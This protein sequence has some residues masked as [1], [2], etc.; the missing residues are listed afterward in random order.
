[1]GYADWRCHSNDSTKTD[2]FAS[3]NNVGLLNMMGKLGLTYRIHVCCRCGYGFTAYVDGEKSEVVAVGGGLCGVKVENGKHT[4]K[5]RYISHGFWIGF[6]MSVV[7]MMISLVYCFIMKRR[8]L[9]ENKEIEIKS[10]E[11]QEI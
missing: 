7:G 8:N 5:L 4:V 11:C 9:M 10:D 2:L 1:M 6:L 3:S